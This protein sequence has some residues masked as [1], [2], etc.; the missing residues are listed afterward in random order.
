MQSVPSTHT[1]PIF[2]RLPHEGSVAKL[3][4][5]EYIEYERSEKTYRDY[6]N[7]LKY[8]KQIGKKEGR[9][10]GLKE[11]LKKGRRLT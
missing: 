2:R 5:A 1:N 6:H 11:G 7:T 9:E 10:E 4:R 8:Q 3:S